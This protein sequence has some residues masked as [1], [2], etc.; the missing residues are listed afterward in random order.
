[1]FPALKAWN[2][3]H[4]TVPS[5]AAT[6][7]LGNRKARSHMQCLLSAKQG[8]GVVFITFFSHLK[9]KR[10]PG[11]RYF[12]FLMRKASER[13]RDLSSIPELG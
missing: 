11:G 3:N 5:R 2:L 13:N 12:C 6:V 4:W 10:I 8:L 1:M 9:L 7:H